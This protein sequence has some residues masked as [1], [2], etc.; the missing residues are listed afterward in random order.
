M[1]V[2]GPVLGL[3]LVLVPL[4]VVVTSP[5]P[6]LPGVSL[7]ERVGTTMRGAGVAIT[8]TSTTNILVFL[9]GKLSSR[10]I[11][12]TTD[13]SLAAQEGPPGSPPSAPTASSLGSASSSPSSYRCVWWCPWYLWGVTLALSP[14]SSPS[15]WPASPWTSGGSRRGGTACAAGGDD[16][17]PST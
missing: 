2:L 12:T 6:S 10:R 4:V 1:L 15:S 3:M 16:V 7:V 11:S 13:L 8:V 14:P 5:Q 17:F 9:I